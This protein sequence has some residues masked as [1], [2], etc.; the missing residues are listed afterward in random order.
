MGDVG[1]G[2]TTLAML[3]SKA[4]LDAGRSVAIYSL[5]RLLN[6]IREAIDA[7]EGKLDFLDRLTAVDLLHIDDLGAENTHR[8]GARAA[9]LDRQRALRGR[10]RD[11]R[12]DQPR[13]RGAR[14]ADRRAHRLA[15][16][17]DLRRSAAV[18]RRGQAPARVRRVVARAPDG[19]RGVETSGAVHSTRHAGNRHSRRPVGRRGQGQDHRPA[20]RAGRRGRA[21]SG[22]QQRRPH[23]RARGRGVEAAPDPLGHPLPGQA[24][25]DRQ[26]RGDR[27]ARAD[28][29]AR[30]A[31]RAAASTSAGCAS[32]P[33]RT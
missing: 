11:R 18:V 28:R 6:L 30:R 17:G 13:S 10:A 24:L 8:L 29:G 14:R 26:R 3:V 33:T 16:G 1:T 7:D 4:A 9:L 2:K 12:H 21:L 23:D 32:P 22:R 20:R 19:R 31:A 5:P 15:A 25:R 27:P